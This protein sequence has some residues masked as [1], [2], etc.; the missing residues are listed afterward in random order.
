[1]TGKR[2]STLADALYVGL[3]THYIPSTNLGSLMEN[4]LTAT[5]YVSDLHSVHNEYICFCGT[6]LSI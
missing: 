2:I 4:L 3:G 6:E 1:M 5:L